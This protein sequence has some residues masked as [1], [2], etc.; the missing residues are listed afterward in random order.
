MNSKIKWTFLFL[1]SIL[2]LYLFY[3]STKESFVEQDASS[4]C[5]AKIQMLSKNQWILKKIDT[6]NSDLL[7]LTWETN[8][9]EKVEFAVYVKKKYAIL[10]RMDVLKKNSWCM[11]NQSVFAFINF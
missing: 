5:I 6:Y 3:Q 10:N 2:F 4:D 11:Q 1:L 7:F 9:K 8:D